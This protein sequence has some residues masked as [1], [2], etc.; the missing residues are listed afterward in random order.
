MSANSVKTHDIYFGTESGIWLVTT[1]V[2]TVVLLMMTGL[3]GN[4]LVLII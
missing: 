2:M 4:V 1:R 3:L